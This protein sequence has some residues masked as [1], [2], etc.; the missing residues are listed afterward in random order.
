MYQV[1]SN[2]LDIISSLAVLEARSGAYLIGVYNGF[3]GQ[4]PLNIIFL[5]DCAYRQVNNQWVKS[6]LTLDPS[7][8][9][10]T[11]IN[12]LSQLTTHLS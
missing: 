10:V 5:E 9:E 8:W 4:A 11:P 1:N 6:N 7:T 3:V 2:H 12:P